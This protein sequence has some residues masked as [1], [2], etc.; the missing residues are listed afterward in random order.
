MPLGFVDKLGKGLPLDGYDHVNSYQMVPL[1]GQR[2]LVFITDKF[3]CTLTI[4]DSN[5]CLMKDFRFFNGG[6]VPGTPE[7]GK[8]VRETIL[9]PSAT[10]RFTVTGNLAGFTGVKFVEDS[11]FQTSAVVTLS[12]KPAKEV[13]F[14]FVFLADL[15]HKNVRGKIEPRF[16]MDTVSKV[17]LDQSNLSLREF[18]AMLDVTVLR[19]LGDPI[20]SSE[21]KNLDAI[22]A[23]TT[24]ETF[25]TV[26]FIVYCCWN[27]ER[28]RGKGDTRGLAIDRFSTKKRYAFIEVA[29]ATFADQAHALAHEIGHVLGLSHT[30]DN[31][32]MFSTVAGKSNLLFGG[33]I[34]VVNAAP[35]VAP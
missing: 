19:D 26:D 9:P 15:I 21:D 29:T 11:E 23:A 13:K 35:G 10:V 20:I 24:E 31:G 32:L 7:A 33:D 8:S 34:E 2:D 16:L 30:K 27:I 22:E 6:P 14:S 3:P 4:Q 25:N 12:V 18:G 28:V 1:N 5:K 17:F